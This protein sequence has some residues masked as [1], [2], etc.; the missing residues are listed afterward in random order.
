MLGSPAVGRFLNL[1]CTGSKKIPMWGIG[2]DAS[3]GSSERLW[4]QQQGWIG[5]FQEDPSTRQVI[6]LAEI[7]S[8][9]VKV[10]VVVQAS[11]GNAWSGLQTS[12]SYY[13]LRSRVAINCTKVSVDN[14]NSAWLQF[15]E[16][17][18]FHVTYNSTYEV[19]TLSVVTN[20][21]F[22][23]VGANCPRSFVAHSSILF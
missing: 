18:P 23:H 3:R 21:C 20:I 14:W 1:S 11:W 2:I 15:L 17:S 19:N 9:N 4:L 16:T 12:F 22:G 7:I 6:A 13:M 8:N 5:I 10:G